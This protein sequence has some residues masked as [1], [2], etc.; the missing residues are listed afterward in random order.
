MS[1][2]HIQKFES[3]MF[4]Y[5]SNQAERAYSLIEDGDVD[6]GLSK[7]AHL[8]DVLQLLVESKQSTGVI[9]IN[10]FAQSVKELDENDKDGVYVHFQ[11]HGFGQ[12]I[13]E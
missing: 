11:E 13:P 12:Y 7:L 2:T 9:S 8:A 5:C 6:N 10:T 3:S 4:E 1:Q